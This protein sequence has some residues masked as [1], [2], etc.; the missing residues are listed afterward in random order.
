MQVERMSAIVSICATGTVVPAG[1]FT[2]GTVPVDVFANTAASANALVSEA[3][4]P[5]PDP[6]PLYEL[7][8]GASGHTAATVV[9]SF[10]LINVELDKLLH[11][12]NAAISARVVLFV[13]A[14]SPGLPPVATT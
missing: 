13:P 3:A 10:R 2:P 9:N 12:P 4:S 14:A 11:V 5:V 8:N 1:T 7:M 6:I